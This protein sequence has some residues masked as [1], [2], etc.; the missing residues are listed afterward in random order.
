[1]IGLTVLSIL[2]SPEPLLLDEETHLWIAQ[3]S[4]WSRPYDWPMPFEP[5]HDTGFVFA[6]PP[7]FL[8]WLKLVG[9]S[10]W[11]AAPWLFLWW[12]SAWKLSVHYKVQPTWVLGLLALSG[13]VMMPLTRGMMPDLMVSALCLTA[14]T[15]YLTRPS[16]MWLS[17]M[18]MGL[19]C[20]TKYPA[21]ML[22]FV[23][24]LLERR[25]QRWGPFV[26]M[27]MLVFVLGEGWLYHQYG[28]WHLWTVL[29]EAQVVGRGSLLDRLVGLPVRLGVSMLPLAII[30]WVRKP[31]VVVGAFAVSV[32]LLGAPM[33][34]FLMLGVSV[35]SL[36]WKRDSWL[37][38]W[39]LLVWLGVVVGHNYTA[40]RYWLVACVPLVILGVQQL[41]GWSIKWKLLLVV[42]CGLWTALLLYTERLHANQQ[43]ELAET[44]VAE[45]GGY[46]ETQS[47]AFS[48]EWTFRAHMLKNGYEPYDG[49]QQWVVTALNSAGWM[50]HVDDDWERIHI[51][52]S[53][54]SWVHLSNPSSSIGWYADTLGQYPVFISVQ[55]SPIE[56][57]E[58]W[59]RQ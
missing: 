20:W 40:P 18:V 31:L 10:V 15:V 34:G 7:L 6:H 46:T 51:W 16:L 38:V 33:A 30:G 14:M 36:L 49:S 3:Q 26:G 59:K 37:V 55:P 21:M 2:L 41:E 43:A 56:R 53:E 27:A 58:L 28:Q 22:L 42:V 1:M 25:V 57:V 35:A 52:E 48:G 29:Q 44:I 54:G 24:L 13:G 4:S 11:G 39:V 45:I 12:G 19:A 47:V 8:W 32:W 23:P 17:G 5:F 50:P 9:Q